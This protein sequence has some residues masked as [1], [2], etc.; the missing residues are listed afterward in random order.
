M[1]S[2]K[3]ERKPDAFL[4][5]ARLDD[6]VSD[7]Y[8]SWLR[9]RL[10]GQVNAEIGKGSF[11][12]FQDTDEIK[13]G[14][15]WAPALEEALAGARFLIPI[16]SPSYFAS[17]PCL[18]ELAKFHGFESVSN[19][20]D[21]IIPI[22]FRDAPN[23]WEDPNNPHA[24]LLRDRQLFDWRHLRRKRRDD[25]EV[26]EHIERLAADIKAAL[27]R[28]ASAARESDTPIAIITAPEA[29]AAMTEKL[30]EIRASLDRSQMEAELARAQ[31][32]EAVEAHLAER[33]RLT[34]DLASTSSQLTGVR[35]E[36]GRL[37]GELSSQANELIQLRSALNSAE[38][39][40]SELEKDR[41][42]HSKAQVL[43]NDLSSSNTQLKTARAEIERQREE[44][45]AVQENLARSQSIVSSSPSSASTHREYLSEPSEVH[46]KTQSI[47]PE[48]ISS[49]DDLPKVDLPFFSSLLTKVGLRLQYSVPPSSADETRTQAS[50]TGRLFLILSIAA[51]IAV[52]LIM[53]IRETTATGQQV[54]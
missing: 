31:L 51:L 12:I 29:L 18:F 15:N 44:I 42:L 25:P 53:L 7:G 5:Y 20:T 45:D 13:A 21:L 48:E 47:D 46:S 34:T 52:T 3:G 26:L 54:S 28:T 37:A 38:N 39:K 1:A 23:H 17:Q 32:R 4:S 41:G 49:F 24:N 9:D 43:E 22:Y 16:L 11:W 33:D 8:I 14:T 30:A 36:Y 10:E 35:D 2:A 27:L 6:Q 19:R 50:T 40:A